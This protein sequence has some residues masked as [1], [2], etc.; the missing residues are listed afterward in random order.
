MLDLLEKYKPKTT[1]D[2]IGQNKGIQELKNFVLNYKSGTAL[3]IAGPT[4]IGKT[5]SVIA[6][7]NELNYDL[8]EINSSNQ[9]NSD[10]IKSIVSNSSKQKS[11]FKRGKIIL[12]DEL[13]GISGNKD[14]GGV[15]ALLQA[16]KESRYPIIITVNDIWNKN[17]ISLRNY[18]KIVVFNRIRNTS[19][20]KFLKLIALKENKIIPDSVINQISMRSNGDL[21]SAL[22]DFQILITGKDKIESKDLEILFDRNRNEN[23]FNALS[24]IFNTT[25]FDTAVNSLNDIDETLDTVMLWIQQ[26]LPLV[27]KKYRDLYNGYYYLSLSDIFYTRIRRWQNWRY[28]VYVSIFLTAGIAL[29]KQE[30]YRG[31]VKFQYPNQMKRRSELKKENIIREKIINN[32]SFLFHC[33]RDYIKYTLDLISLIFFMNKGLSSYY[34]KNEKISKEEIE[35]LNQRGKKLIK[36]IKIRNT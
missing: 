6:L 31:F 27:Y 28:L 2:I 26:N 16:I 33:S 8:I 20:V 23:I 29:S 36:K 32:L 4:G 14:R 30:R 25:D 19:I 18:C 5:S 9:R 1:K 17:L 21:R 3:I 24:L 12:V 34:L 15:S 35:F 22:I 10:N 7:A 11:L 13:D